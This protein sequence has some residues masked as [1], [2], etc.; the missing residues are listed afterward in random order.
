MEKDSAKEEEDSEED[1]G[2][3]VKGGYHPVELGDTF[4]DDRYVV[5]RKL[6]WSFFSTSWLAKDQ[7]YVP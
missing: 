3:Y 7:K 4:S 2:D 5:I 1:W 6:G